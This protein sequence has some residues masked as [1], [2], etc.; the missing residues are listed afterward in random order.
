MSL[1]DISDVLRHA[2]PAGSSMGLPIHHYETI[3]STMIE[4]SRLAAQ[5]A[6]AGTMILAEMQTDGRGRLGRRWHSEESS[7]IYFTLILRPQLSPAAAPVLTLMAGVSLA[8]VVESLV[9]GMVDLR[10]PND[11]LVNGRKC[12]GILVE[13]R[14]EPDSIDHVL[15]GIGI[16]VNQTDFPAGLETEP[17]SLQL[18]AGRPIQRAD[19]L[20]SLL[21]QLDTDYNSLLTAGPAATIQRFEHI[22]SYARGRKV[23]VGE[24]GNYVFGVTA[25]LAS[26]GILLLRRENGSVERIVAGHVRPA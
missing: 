23:R 6:A 21:K 10:W 19:L 15:L 12:A 1:H 25:G 14:A 3:D 11:L 16:N 7:G 17:S 22:S 9:P 18:E 4:A 24:D 2:L 13:M 8:T 20:I 26:D 5:G